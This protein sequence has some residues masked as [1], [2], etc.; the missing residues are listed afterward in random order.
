MKSLFD[1]VIALCVYGLLKAIVFARGVIVRSCV[2]YSA[3]KGMRRGLSTLHSSF[4][5]LT[6]SPSKWL[7]DSNRGGLVSIELLLVRSELGL[8]VAAKAFLSRSSSPR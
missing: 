8:L 5:V 7:V 3:S 1:I 2:Q 6:E 4:V